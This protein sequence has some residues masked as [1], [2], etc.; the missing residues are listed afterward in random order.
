M[1]VVKSVA[2]V[3]GLFILACVGLQVLAVFLGMA[4]GLVGIAIKLAVVAGLLYLVY[5]GVRVLTG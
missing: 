2:M 4:L 1:E 3:I 5:S